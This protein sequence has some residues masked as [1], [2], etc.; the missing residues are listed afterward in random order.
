MC[1]CVCV[2]VYFSSAQGRSDCSNFARHC[3][4]LFLYLMSRHKAPTILPPV[5][6]HENYR[7]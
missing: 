5:Y 2:C 3:L 1:V 7:S 6:H 4:V